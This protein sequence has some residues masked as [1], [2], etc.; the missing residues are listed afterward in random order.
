MKTYTLESRLLYWLFV[1]GIPVIGAVTSGFFIW[2]AASRPMP[3][4]PTVFF[5]FWFI[6]M[7]W[8]GY[9]QATM[10]HTIQVT[11]TGT[12]RFV[13]TQEDH[14]RR[15]LGCDLGKGVG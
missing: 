8:G 7:L 14:E 12:I 1:F 11:D 2:L 3:T 13:G 5:I 6:A 9:R 15:T 10:P 4:G